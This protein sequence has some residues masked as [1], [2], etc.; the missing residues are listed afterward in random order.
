MLEVHKKSNGF[1]LI[2][3]LV[4]IAIIGVLASVVLVSLSSAREKSR[5]AARKAALQEVAKALELYH[6]DNGTYSI[7][8]A[9]AGGNG[10]GWFSY[11]GGA[12]PKSVAQQLKD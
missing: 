2:E 12:Y 3:L 1:T 5:D 10:N 11:V 6:L 9:G 4:V 8:G 7:L